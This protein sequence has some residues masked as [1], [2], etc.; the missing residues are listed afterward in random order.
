[1][2]DLAGFF[3]P[4]VIWFLIGLVLLVLELIVPGFVIIFFGA[5]AWVTAIVCLLFPIRINLQVGI[6]TLSSVLLL[7]LLRRYLRRQFFS[8]DKSVVETLT[9][10]FIGKTAVVESDIKK[11]HPGKVSFKGTTWNALSDVTIKKGQ[12]VEIIGKESINLIV[13]PIK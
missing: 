3:T 8:E 7:L 10:E 1:M 11:G 12:P 9:D 2:S 6:F 13:K 4:T 5:G